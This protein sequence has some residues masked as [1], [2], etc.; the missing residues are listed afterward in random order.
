MN[1]WLLI[2]STTKMLCRY[3][4][5]RL[6][7]LQF[8]RSMVVWR[9]PKQRST[10]SRSDLLIDRRVLV[11]NQNFLHQNSNLL[12]VVDIFTF[13]GDY[14]MQVDPELNPRGIWNIGFVEGTSAG[15]K[16]ISWSDSVFPGAKYSSL[17]PPLTGKEWIDDKDITPFP[18]LDV[19]PSSLEATIKLIPERWLDIAKAMG[20]N[21]GPFKPHRDDFISHKE[22][23]P[24][25]YF[26]MIH[27]AMTWGYVQMD[28][29]T[30]ASEIAAVIQAIW[31]TK[32]LP[33]NVALR[34]TDDTDPF[35]NPDDWRIRHFFDKHLSVIVD[36][37]EYLVNDGEAIEKYRP[38][39]LQRAILS[40]FSW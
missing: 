9:R 4:V 3:Q 13:G 18:A 5:W 25:K 37:K 33:Q 36:G 30:S 16:L 34:L 19:P 40:A 38:S 21:R 31:P 7:S 15:K 10:G 22:N 29:R 20:V 17:G 28:E 32:T 6:K 2:S 11:N 1:K 27:P 39:H 12:S 26:L 24:Q 14:A 35:K 8:S 23:L